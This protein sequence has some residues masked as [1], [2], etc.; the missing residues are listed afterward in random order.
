MLSAAGLLGKADSNSGTQEQG[1]RPIGVQE[2][3]VFSEQVA[4]EL[5]L[6][7]SCQLEQEGGLLQVEG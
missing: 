2:S 3:A 1:W 5:P 7:R 6:E 4:F